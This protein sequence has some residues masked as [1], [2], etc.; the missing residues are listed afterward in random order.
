MLGPNGMIMIHGSPERVLKVEV[1]NVELVEATLASTE[2]EHIKKSV[3]TSVTTL[4]AKPRPGPVFQ[5]AKET[6]KF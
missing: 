3:D 5:L 1:T 4:P 2:L 6:K